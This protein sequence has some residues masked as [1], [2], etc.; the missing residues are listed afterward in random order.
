MT[1]TKTIGKPCTCGN[2]TY[3][4]KYKHKRYYG[5]K[6]KGWMMDIYICENCGKKYKLNYIEFEDIKCK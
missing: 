6:N 2:T 1:W 4:V 3:K 5:E